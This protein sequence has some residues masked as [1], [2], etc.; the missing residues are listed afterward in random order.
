MTITKTEEKLLSLFQS[1]TDKQKTAVL[2]TIEKWVEENEE[3]EKTS[4][5][6]PIVETKKED[7]KYIIPD[8]PFVESEKQEI[9]FIIEEPIVESEKQEIKFIIEEPKEK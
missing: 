9:K 8:K 4:V 2:M 6:M 1:L 7:I 5:I 3:N